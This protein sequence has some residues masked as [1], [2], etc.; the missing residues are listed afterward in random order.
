MKEG[1]WPSASILQCGF[2]K[3]CCRQ[4][5]G[6]NALPD[7]GNCCDDVNAIVTADSSWAVGRLMPSPTSSSNN[8]TNATT[9]TA[10]ACSESSS[11]ESDCSGEKTTVAVV[12]GVLGAL[13]GILLLGLASMWFLWR[14]SCAKGSQQ[15]SNGTRYENKIGPGIAAVLGNP[16]ELEAIHERRELP[17]SYSELD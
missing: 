13:F 9:G 2:G 11:V 3:W 8:T 17:A 12:G 1:N 6:A 7:P 16:T 4:W 15:V 10:T 5:Y 14:R